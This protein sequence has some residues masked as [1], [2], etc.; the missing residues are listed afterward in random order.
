[1]KRLTLL[2]TGFLAITGCA[3]TEKID[4]MP[5]ASKVEL[6][7]SEANRERCDYLGDLQGSAKS[8]DL[9]VATMNSRNDLRNKSYQL[10]AN[11]ITMDSSS[12]ANAMDFTGRNQVVITGRAYKC[13]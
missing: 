12:A 1:M 8:T 5:D 11:F 4:L 3:V 7:K 6:T 2:I 13:L 10:G 9:G